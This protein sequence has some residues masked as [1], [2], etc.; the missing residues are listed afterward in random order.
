MA[1]DDGQRETIISHA[2]RLLSNRDYPKTICPSEIARALSSEELEM[3]GVA[4]WRRTMD[5]IRELVWEKRENGEV[6]VMQ[7]GNVVH[8]EKLGDI[9]GPIRV[10]NVKK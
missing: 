4:D 2:N 1:L 8:A 9:K 6:E 3:L 5:S 10:R 7:K